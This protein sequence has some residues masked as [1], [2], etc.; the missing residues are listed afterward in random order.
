MSCRI[1][2]VQGPGNNSVFPSVIQVEYP[3][4]IVTLDIIISGTNRYEGSTYPI[5]QIQVE[6]ITLIKASVAGEL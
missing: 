1:F 4:H 2:L 3:I 5:G 6:A